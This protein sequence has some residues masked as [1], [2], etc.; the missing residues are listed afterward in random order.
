MTNF[1]DEA[2]ET[3]VDSVEV[4]PESETGATEVV[5]E[6]S[7]TD[8]TVEVSSEGTAEAEVSEEQ[9]SEAA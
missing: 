6:D 8:A 2:T 7:S 3:T 4:T 5:A 1:E 9:P